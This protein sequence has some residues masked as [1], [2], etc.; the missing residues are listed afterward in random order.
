MSDDRPPGDSGPE[1]SDKLRDLPA[2]QSHGV[3]GGTPRRATG[4]KLRVVTRS[5]GAATP[6]DANGDQWPRLSRAEPGPGAQL[7]NRIAD[8]SAEPVTRSFDH[9]RTTLLKTLKSHGWSR[10]AIAAPTRGCGTT[11]SA[12][13]LALSLARVPG[14]RTALLDLNL[15]R[16]GLAAALELHR[17]GD[18]GGFLRGQVRPAD[19]MLRISDRLALGLTQA[20]EA[21]PADLLQSDSCAA[22]IGDLMDRLMPDVL[23]CDLP[24]LL[25]HDDLAAFLPQVDGVL[26]VADGTQTLPD[27]IAACERGLNG[28]TKVLGVVLN[29]A[30]LAG[31]TPI[32]A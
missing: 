1:F 32:H 9:L 26:L 15:R 21:D 30:R 2:P 18:M 29:Q 27:H 10:V 14:S 23:L 31:P 6:A 7:L 17:A 16:P 3:F 5:T 28:Q 8:G 13:H 25:D 20:T 24:P 4:A 22:A 11:F 12:I 19:H